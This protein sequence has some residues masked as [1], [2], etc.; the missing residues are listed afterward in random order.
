MGKI[1][2]QRR[3]YELLE[4]LYNH[5][6]ASLV[7]GHSTLNAN[8]LPGDVFTDGLHIN[9]H[10]FYQA[11]S[12]LGICVP[13]DS[14]IWVMPLDYKPSMES[15]KQVMD[16]VALIRHPETEPQSVRN[17]IEANIHNTQLN[18]SLGLLNKYI[19]RGQKKRFRTVLRC[20]DMD[21]DPEKFIKHCIK[22]ACAEGGPS[23]LRIKE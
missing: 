13:I 8:R 15:A 9:K 10:L 21:D 18:H 1:I 3:Y 20:M 5:H 19:P 12:F 23:F 22:K 4:Q 7:T 6:H 17:E 16:T 14:K 2:R 11:V